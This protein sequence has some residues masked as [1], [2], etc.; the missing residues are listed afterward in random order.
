MKTTTQKEEEE[1]T[2]QHKIHLANDLCRQLFY[3]QKTSM[4]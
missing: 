2:T 1:E 4:E 3:A